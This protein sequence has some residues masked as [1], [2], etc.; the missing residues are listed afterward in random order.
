MAFS[1]EEKVKE[2]C[3][4][5]TEYIFLEPAGFPICCPQQLRVLD[6][7]SLVQI[8][9]VS[10]HEHVHNVEEV[11]KV[12]KEDPSKWEGVLQLPEAGSADDEDQIVH[13]GE[14]DD[15]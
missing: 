13:D 12:V 1:R 11:T 14:V 15:D 2:I 10:A 4:K 5:N 6:H 8:T 9:F 3:R 7:Y